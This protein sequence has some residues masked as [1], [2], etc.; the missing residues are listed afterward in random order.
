MNEQDVQLNVEYWFRKLYEVWGQLLGVDF[1]AIPAKLASIW[2][3]IS[4]VSYLFSAIGLAI[5]VYTTIRI[6]DL[7]KREHE[8]FA[9]LIG[10]PEKRRDDQRFAH[11]ESLME[12]ATPSDWRQAIIEADIMLDEALQQAGY[13]GADL[14]ERLKSISTKDLATLQDAWEAHK[15]RNQIAHLGSAYPLSQT[16]AQRTI[17]RYK[18]VFRELG[19]I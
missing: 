15:V 7:R 10:A 3:W 9:T 1:S 16:E 12:S 6:F 19:V 8:E 2:L 14:G 4:V 13:R 5:I 11:I 18:A 17:A